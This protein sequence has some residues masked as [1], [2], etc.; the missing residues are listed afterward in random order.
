[1][2]GPAH[3]TRLSTQPRPMRRAA[4]DLE[5]F[6]RLL[7][8]ETTEH[9]LLFLDCEGNVTWWGRG[10]ERMF[11]YAPEE[12]VGKPGATLFVPEDV[13]KG[14][15]QL[16]LEIAANNDAAEDDRWQLRK[17]G[18]RFWAVG[19]M[20]ALREHGSLAGFAKL[21]RNRTDLREQLDTLR[22][23]AAALDQGARRRDAFISTLSHELRNPLAPLANAVQI[24]RMASPVTHE[25]QFA[26]RVVERQIDLMRRL[27]DDLLDVSRLNAGK[28]ELRRERICLTDVLRAAAHDVEPVTREKQHEVQL[29]LAHGA[30][31]VDG[32]RE[33]L[34]QV[35]VNLLT[36]AAKYT[37]PRGHI[38]VMATIEGNEAVV[39][40]E[41]DGVGIPN[42][43]LPRIFELFT[44]VESSRSLASG[45]LGIGLSLV[46]DL[47]AMH[48]GSVQV[49]SDGVGKGAE[50]TV[51]LPLAGH[52]GEVSASLPR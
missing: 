27:V 38:W 16:E 12:I 45:G 5:R 4:F 1:M 52:G 7:A 3:P 43:M 20:V 42:D 11:G 41:D 8:A 10:A 48:Q 17:D 50:F 33:R 13:Q 44:Q 19:A 22:N 29:L 51:R 14:V 47:V 30:I 35:F 32:D 25:V 31:D 49:R 24:I 37:R 39:K 23:H 26:L 36:N 2:A 46:K 34:H 21:L 18:S 6:L 40:V 9:A 15:P 28:I